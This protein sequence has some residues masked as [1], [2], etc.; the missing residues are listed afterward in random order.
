MYISDI[1]LMAGLI[2]AAAG[3]YICLKPRSKKNDT[4]KIPERVPQ[5]KVIEAERT[6]AIDEE[7]GVSLPSKS[8]ALSEDEIR[9]I[10]S[11]PDLE[12]VIS[13]KK[14]RK[15]MEDNGYVFHKPADDPK[16]K[17]RKKPGREPRQKP[18]EDSEPKPGKKPA[19]KADP[20]P[21][22]QP[23]EEPAKEPLENNPKENAVSVEEK[24]GR[25]YYPASEQVMS[26]PENFRH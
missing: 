23:K 26:E 8:I 12:K 16:P 6:E 24:D 2:G 3:V 25:T 17:T 7:D 19:V 22:E 18:A 14:V 21:A 4:P 10:E 1:L 13:Q 11:E 9:M 20:K 15:E 5:T